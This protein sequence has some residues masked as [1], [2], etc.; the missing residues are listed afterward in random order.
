[1]G[2]CEVCENDKFDLYW[3]DSLGLAV[4]EKCLPEEDN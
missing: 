1:M 2:D 3:S 4:C